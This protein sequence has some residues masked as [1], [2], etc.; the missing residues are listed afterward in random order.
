METVSVKRRFQYCMEIE[1]DEH[2]IPSNVTPVFLAFNKANKLV[3]E[4]LDKGSPLANSV[5]LV[6]QD[7]KD[8]R[9]EVLVASL[10]SDGPDSMKNCMDNITELRRVPGVV[11]DIKRN[12]IRLFEEMK[13][14]V[15]PLTASVNA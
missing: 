9:R 12:T 15:G 5:A 2:L 1:Y 14:A 8:L 3:R 4:I 13:A 7:E 6:V 11:E 10:G